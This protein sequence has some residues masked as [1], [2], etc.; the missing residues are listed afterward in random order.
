MP[1]RQLR[2]VFQ[3]VIHNL[4]TKHLVLTGRDLLCLNIQRYYLKLLKYKEYKY[5]YFCDIYVDNS[6]L[7]EYYS[8]LA[9][10]NSANYKNDEN[11]TITTQIQLMGEHFKLA[12]RGQ[13]CL[14]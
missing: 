8:P 7:R 4:S 2:T 14:M 9:A 12:S 5:K 10:D 11:L 3:E 1:C 13:I 6:A